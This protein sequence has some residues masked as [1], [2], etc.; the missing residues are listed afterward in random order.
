MT[1][2]QDAAAADAVLSDPG[3]SVRVALLDKM[4][5]FYLKNGREAKTVHLTPILEANL[6]HHLEKEK[7]ETATRDQLFGLTLVKN[8]TEFRLE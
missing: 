4:K 3:Y 2:E 8:A 6:F 7:V 1:I 5:E